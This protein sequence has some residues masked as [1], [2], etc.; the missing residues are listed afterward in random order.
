MGKVKLVAPDEVLRGTA[1]EDSG[2]S[3]GNAS[4]GGDSL[5]SWSDGPDSGS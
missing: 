5:D 3:W 2:D 4:N 1:A